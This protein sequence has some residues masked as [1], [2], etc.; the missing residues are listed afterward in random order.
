MNYWFVGA[1]NLADECGRALVRWLRE[2]MPAGS[3]TAKNTYGI[4][5]PTGKFED[6]VFI[7]Q[8]KASPLGMTDMTGGAGIYHIG[9]A[10]WLMQNIWDFYKTTRDIDYLRDEIYPIMR[11]S[12]NF[13]AQYL[14]LFKIY[15]AKY[16]DGYYYTTGA[17]RS[18]ENGPFTT[19][20]KYDL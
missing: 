16:A 10:A 11:V 14:R 4:K 13:Y 2:Q 19:G 7:M 5:N 1:A 9:N 20:V 12:A 8:T 18:P 15:N 17:A 6:D 3:V